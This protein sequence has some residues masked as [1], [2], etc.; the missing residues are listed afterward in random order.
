MIVIG[1]SAALAF[2]FFEYGT[3]QNV[4][5]L[6]DSFWWA[7]VTVS[8]VGYGDIYP[9]TTG[10]RLTAMLLMLIGVGVLGSYVAAITNY[11]VGNRS[12]GG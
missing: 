8:T 6:F 2:H 10:G 9:V 4:H 3:N 5:S 7:M 1:L 11:V 12:E